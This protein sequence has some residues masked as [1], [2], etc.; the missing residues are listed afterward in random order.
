METSIHT[1]WFR[2]QY[3]CDSVSGL[4]VHSE[5]TFLGFRNEVLQAVAKTEYQVPPC[6]CPFCFCQPD[7]FAAVWGKST[8]SRCC[9]CYVIVCGDDELT[10]ASVVHHTASVTP[11]NI[12]QP[13]DQLLCDGPLLI[14]RCSLL[15]LAMHV[16]F[17]TSNVL[18]FCLL[19]SFYPFIFCVPTHL[20]L[21]VLCLAL[22][23]HFLMLM[24]RVLTSVCPWGP[25]LLL[26]LLPSLNL[27][28]CYFYIAS[29]LLLS[30]VWLLIHRCS[31]LTVSSFLVPL[32]FFSA[33][34]R[35]PCR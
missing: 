32:L 19:C 24:V 18:S 1:D 20:F 31:S 6:R 14:Q 15:S 2:F 27:S 8:L 12:C 33:R 11:H 30:L 17:V 21:P 28:W 16:C 23:S 29:F 5:F 35:L 10:S 3:T 25:I 9:R 26:L 4:I 34:F 13:F 22:P 7:L